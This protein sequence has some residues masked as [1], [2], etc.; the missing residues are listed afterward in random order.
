MKRWI[1]IR[2]SHVLQLIAKLVGYLV[3]LLLSWA[4]F[5]IDN[6]TGES[7]CDDITAYF[8][9]PTTVLGSVSSICVT[10]DNMVS[11]FVAKLCVDDLN[12]PFPWCIYHWK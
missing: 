6:A 1:E 10:R 5:I 8:S 9:I 7:V 12:G 4:H 11:N 3:A 2:K